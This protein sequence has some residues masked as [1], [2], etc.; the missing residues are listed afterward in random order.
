VPIVEWQVV[1]GDGATESG[2]GPPP[3]TV[4]HTYADDGVYQA[5]L[6]V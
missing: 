4:T 2:K 6:I 3:D 1:Y 5:V